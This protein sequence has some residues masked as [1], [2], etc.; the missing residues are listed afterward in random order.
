MDWPSIQHISLFRNCLIMRKVT[1][2][3]EM[4]A[5][6]QKVVALTQFLLHGILS[7]YTFVFEN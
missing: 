7:S 5:L 2:T 4:V 1:L 6:T 3:Q